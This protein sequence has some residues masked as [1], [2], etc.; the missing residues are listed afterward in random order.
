MIKDETDIF[1]TIRNT[2]DD[3]LRLRKEQVDGK[4]DQ[5]PLER[6]TD[7]NR[8]ALAEY[9]SFH[10]AAQSGPTVIGQLVDI[11]LKLDGFYNNAKVVE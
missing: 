3:F 2:T 9:I 7:L 8:F 11:Q 5:T 4:T 6:Y 10:I 1:K